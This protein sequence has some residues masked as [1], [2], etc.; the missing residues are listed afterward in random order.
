MRLV[1]ICSYR[2]SASN[3]PLAHKNFSGQRRESRVPGS[4][5]YISL[6]WG[7]ARCLPT[8]AQVTPWFLFSSCWSPLFVLQESHWSLNGMWRKI[9][10]PHNM[11]T[12]YFYYSGFLHGKRKIDLA[13]WER[14]GGDNVSISNPEWL[15]EKHISGIFLGQH[16]LSC[17]IILKSRDWAN[18]FDEQI[19]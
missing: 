9:K 1:V 14:T 17:S 13:E 11:G 8:L 4:E 3:W 12:T 2:S 7:R 16:L 10:H 19:C 15:G 6:S 5:T 18:M